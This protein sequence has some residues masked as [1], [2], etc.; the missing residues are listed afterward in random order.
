MAFPSL[1]AQAVQPRINAS[2][3]HTWLQYSGNHKFSKRWGLHAEA[4]V[5]RTVMLDEWQQLL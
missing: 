5:R 2:H 4:Q 1:Q 3:V